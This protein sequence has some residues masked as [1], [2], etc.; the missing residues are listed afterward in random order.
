MTLDMIIN[1]LTYPKLNKLNKIEGSSLLSLNNAFP[2]IFIKGTFDH[3][4]TPT[5]IQSFLDSSTT[6]NTKNGNN[7]KIVT[8]IYPIIILDTLDEG[9]YL[10][11]TMPWFA[12]SI[13]LSIPH[14][15][16][17]RPQARFSS[18]GRARIWTQAVRFWSLVL[19][20]SPT[21]L[22]PRANISPEATPRGQICTVPSSC[23]PLFCSTPSYLVWITLLSTTPKPRVHSPHCSQWP[24]KNVN[25]IIIFLFKTFVFSLPLGANLKSVHGLRAF[26]SIPYHSSA[27]IPCDHSFL[28]TKPSL[29]AFTKVNF[30]LGLYTCQSM[31]LQH[32][33]YYS[34]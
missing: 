27:I 32:A 6:H 28:A 26:L 15:K 3:P 14:M 9:S 29:R 34:L 13:I 18:Q 33:S 20:D 10:F 23:H 12:V 31:F 24:F 8:I 22:S 19:N 7:N 21:S 17:L 4:G 11:I 2:S 16:K 1:S 5:R 25:P 30:F